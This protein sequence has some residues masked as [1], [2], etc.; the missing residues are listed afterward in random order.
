MRFGREMAAVLTIPALKDTIFKQEETWNAGKAQ[1]EF[2]KKL[3][4]N[5]E[6]RQSGSQNEGLYEWLAS[7]IQKGLSLNGRVVPSVGSILGD[8]RWPI[9]FGAI[10]YN[11]YAIAEC[12]LQMH[13][14]KEIVIDFCVLIDGDATLFHNIISRTYSP[15]DFN[16]ATQLIPIVPMEAWRISPRTTLYECNAVVQIFQGQCGDQY[17]ALKPLFWKRAREIAMGWDLLCNSHH[18]PLFKSCRNLPNLY[19]EELEK[20]MI[21]N[22][23]AVLGAVRALMTLCFAYSPPEFPAVQSCHCQTCRFFPRSHCCN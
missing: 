4:H 1:E 11:Q 3:Q 15:R 6:Q 21:A 8:P 7:C 20:E 23:Q 16:F 2:C 5:Y 9:F 12:L 13:I 18:V 22:L 19:L 10:A 14:K 17:N